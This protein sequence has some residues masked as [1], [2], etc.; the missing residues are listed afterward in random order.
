M[1]LIPRNIS[2]SL[3]NNIS[4]SRFPIILSYSTSRFSFLT[5]VCEDIIIIREGLSLN[6]VSVLFLHGLSVFT[7]LRAVLNLYHWMRRCSFIV[8]VNKISYIFQYRQWFLLTFF[9]SRW[10][11]CLLISEIYLGV[12]I[13]F[14]GKLKLCLLLVFHGVLLW[15]L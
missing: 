12:F 9:I 6:L 15:R 5:S 3:K 10:T 7:D 14:L 2:C 8:K 1:R 13:S 11:L 4:E